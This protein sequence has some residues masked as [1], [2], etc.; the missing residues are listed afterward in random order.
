[1]PEASVNTVNGNGF[2]EISRLSIS[3]HSKQLCT[4]LGNLKTD[5]VCEVFR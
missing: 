2:Q 1:M 5:N 4:N 3:D